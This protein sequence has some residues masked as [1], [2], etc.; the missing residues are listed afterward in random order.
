MNEKIKMQINN[1][2]AMTS[3]FMSIS[4]YGL[5]NRLNEEVIDLIECEEDH[6]QNFE[7][8]N[9]LEQ[10]KL[11]IKNKIQSLLPSYESK[12][13]QL[14]THYGLARLYLM[15]GEFEKAKSIFL[16]NEDYE[17]LVIRVCFLKKEYEALL[18]YVDQKLNIDE[19][20]ILKLLD[21][22]KNK[23]FGNKKRLLDKLKN[24]NLESAL[25][26]VSTTIDSL[27][28]FYLN[29]GCH[30][31]IYHIDSDIWY[32][33]RQEFWSIYKFKTALLNTPQN[34]V[35]ISISLLLIHN[36]RPVE[37]ILVSV[38]Q[39]YPHIFKHLEKESSLL[40]NDL[41][42]SKR[43]LLNPQQ[44]SRFREN[45][46]DFNFKFLEEE[47]AEIIGFS[48]IEL[49]A[50]RKISYE[51]ERTV[52]TLLRN[53]FLGFFEKTKSEIDLNN[54]FD[55]KNDVVRWK[56]EQMVFEELKKH[57]PQ[58]TILTQYS[59]K[60]LSPLR[61]D[62]FIKEINLAIE[63]Q[64]EQHFRPIKFFGGTK[65]FEQQVINDKLKKQLCAKNNVDIFYIA[66]YENIKKRITELAEKY[67]S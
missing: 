23:R 52:N 16:D 28:T 3:Y 50:A 44:L 20:T 9:E 30:S 37:E 10:K 27:N 7:L 45:I 1:L 32:R 62:I 63:Y 5:A 14:S 31:N 22:R 65:T 54:N 60:W 17:H 61:L 59:P 53:D 4:R 25:D 58:F 11:T 19:N 49:E 43:Y 55:E 2:S 64:G 67:C 41:I 24:N 13:G 6:R 47:L 21:K 51:N 8:I 38:K 12:L 48:S 39:N 42:K 46:C 40:S 29:K 34:L 26:Y 36:N 15:I 66:Y 57:F 35:V 56:S 33:I 18:E